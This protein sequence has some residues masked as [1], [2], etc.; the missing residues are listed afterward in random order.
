M[1]NPRRCCLDEKP[2]GGR[3]SYRLLSFFIAFT[4]LAVLLVITYRSTIYPH[5]L[6][7]EEKVERN[8]LRLAEN[9]AIRDLKKG[10]DTQKNAQYLARIYALKGNVGRAELVLMSY[11][12]E[13]EIVDLV[14]ETQLSILDQL[15]TTGS[16]LNP[17]ST[18]KL[19]KL[20]KY[21]VYGNLKFFTGYQLALTGDWTGA[22][23]YFSEARRDGI[24]KVLKPY[25][26]YY[27]ARADLVK[28]DNIQVRKAIANLKRISRKYSIPLRKRTILNLLETQL[29]NGDFTSALGLLR[30]L[31][32]LEGAGDKDRSWVSARAYIAVGE[33][34]AKAGGKLDALSYFLR[35]LSVNETSTRASASLKAL[36]ILARVADEPSS[37]GTDSLPGLSTAGYQRLGEEILKLN[38][39]REANHTL[40]RIVENQEALP[41]LRLLSLVSL[42]KLVDLGKTDAE[43]SETIALATNLFE[44]S[45][46]P[47]K[48]T[49]LQQIYLNLAERQINNRRIAPAEAL[50]ETA[51]GL[52]GD[53]TGALLLESYRLLRNTKPLSSL[54]RQEKLLLEAFRETEVNRVECLENLIPILLYRGNLNL[55]KEVIEESKE[56]ESAL[57]RFWERYLER[58]KE[59]HDNLEEEPAQVRKFSYYELFPLNRL[60]WDNLSSWTSK[61][62]LLDIPESVEEYLL[63]YLFTELALEEARS[64][65]RN[66]KPVA[67]PAIY[68]KDLTL[69][70]SLPITRW[71]TLQLIESGVKWQTNRELARFILD[72]AYPKP[73]YEIVSQAGRDY[74]VSPGL[75]YAVMAKESNFDPGAVSPAGAVGLMQILPSTADLY[76]KFLPDRMRALP[77]ADP[78]KNINLG[79]I[80]LREQLKIFKEKHLALAG[81]NAG[82]G[83]VRNWLANINTE[84]P[85]LV[86]ELLPNFEARQFVKKVLK[87]EK[88]YDFLLNEPITSKNQNSME[89]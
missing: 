32:E 70:A 63:S 17:F 42:S 30:Q 59:P 52:K 50:L 16:L 6:T 2:A 38:D 77:L 65:P 60:T 57:A 13:D 23:S 87:Y 28:N 7:L 56:V 10:K 25:L 61:S 9:Q 41:H 4:F 62:L 27:L 22:K 66:G 69:T 39:Q 47:E 46:F 80:Y 55:A 53:L 29:K 21:P 68:A 5:F 67:W 45:S 8:Y 35:A 48:E 11:N 79:A 84:D 31:E 49:A 37:V 85:E 88:V 72:T 14:R 12:V 40:E 24:S 76:T 20:R 15:K 74:A 83:N 36:N 43:M 82:P 58:E 73:Y 86:I 26:S 78:R 34:F 18:G 64:S 51:V 75:I 19:R 71:R 54:D 81:Y 3:T 33:Y 44:Q 89:N 1:H